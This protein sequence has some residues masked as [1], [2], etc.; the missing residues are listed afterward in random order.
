MWRSSAEGPNAE[1]V[2]IKTLKDRVWGEGPGKRFGERLPAPLQKNVGNFAYEMLLFGAYSLVFTS[3]DI[4][5]AL[6]SGLKV[7][8]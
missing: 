8:E 5:F 6:M 7:V 3:H 2:R 4:G 1:G